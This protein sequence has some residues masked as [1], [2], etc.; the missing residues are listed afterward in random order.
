MNIVIVGDGTVGDTLVQYI[1]GEGHNVTVIDQNPNLINRVVN[2]YDVQGV[3]G[4]GA[5]HAVQVEAGVPNADLF[6]A[7]ANTD[8]L[9]MV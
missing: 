3:V 1:S 7:V 6:I 8:A 5:S 9:N 4:N 2:Q